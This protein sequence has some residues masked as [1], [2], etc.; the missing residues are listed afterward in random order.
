MFTSLIYKPIFC[1]IYTKL[2]IICPY[3]TLLQSFYCFLTLLNRFWLGDTSELASDIFNMRKFVIFFIQLFIPQLFV[4]EVTNKHL[5]VC[6]LSENNQGKYLEYLLTW[7][8]IQNLILCKGSIWQLNK[9]EKIT[10]N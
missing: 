1:K 5:T 6:T 8:T 7:K 4:I 9:Y 3:L 10:N 2:G